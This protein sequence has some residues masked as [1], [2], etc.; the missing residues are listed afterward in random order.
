MYHQE[1]L[2]VGLVVPKVEIGKPLV[3]AEEIVR[4][5]NAEKKAEVMLFPELAIA[6]YSI[7]DLVYHQQLQ[8]ENLEAI[9]YILNNNKYHGV[10]ICGAALSI[11]GQLYNCALVIQKNKILGIIP[12]LYFPETREFIESR[13]FSS[14][15]NIIPNVPSINLLGEDVPIG[16]LIFTTYPHNISF[17]VEVCA[18][19]WSIRN[20]NE[21]YYLNGA[22]IVFNLSASSFNIGKGKH[23][24]TLTENASLKGSGAYVYVSSGVTESSSNVLFSGHAI[25][26]TCGETSLDEQNFNFDSVV[27]YDDLD[28]ERIRY[29]RNVNCYLRNNVLQNYREI[30]WELKET[31]DYQFEKPI[32]K[33]PF[34]PK[35]TEELDMISKVQMASVYKRLLHVNTEKV[36]LGV[37]GGLDSTLAL[38]SLVRMCDTYGLERK[39]I[40]GVTMPALATTSES[41]N[42]ATQLMEKLNVTAYE[43]PI[44][45]EVLNQL[46]L[47]NHDGQTKDITYENAQARYRTM[48]LLNLANKEKGI[49][50]GTSDMSEIALGWSTFGGDQFAMYGINA[51]LPKTLVKR[52]VTYYCDIYPEVK[53]ILDDIIAA[54]I[55]PE[56][57]DKD[58]N[59]EAILGD[60][61]INDFILFQHLNCGATHSKIKFLLG[62]VFGLNS[63]ESERYIEN[64]NRR[65]K[66]GQYKRLSSPESVKVLSISLTNTDYRLPGDIK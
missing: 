55:T 6:G 62:V 5:I 34:V 59:T 47:I 27:Y 54:P 23:R 25:V 14:G 16:N 11:K 19:L 9:A 24:R 38:L 1:F 44:K 42:R 61:Q 40:I 56:L 65:F 13:Y 7:G 2:K 29:N 51:G 17:A 18:D 41:K 49:V 30:V 63:K 33:E 28:I 43:I 15:K 21:N 35:T 31:N 39:N 66:M 8:K 10:I 20:L 45:E 3:N 60:Y 22:Q 48:L 4:I 50:I 52:M 37:S 12:K 26:S 58:Q 57:T 46:H 64:F 53:D 36:I 32:D